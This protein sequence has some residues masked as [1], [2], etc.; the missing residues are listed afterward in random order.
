MTNSTAHSYSAI[1]PK[2]QPTSGFFADGLLGEAKTAHPGWESAL[3]S[4]SS[5][6]A[7]SLAVLATG[8]GYVTTPVPTCPEPL[9][10]V[11]S[12]QSR[13]GATLA[14]YETGS[15]DVSKANRLFTTDRYILSFLSWLPSAV[16]DIYGSDTKI[17]LRSVDDLDTGDMILEAR[18]L[19][20]LELDDDF[21]EKDATLFKKIEMSGFLDGMRHVIVSQG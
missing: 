18:V 5:N 21:D 8:V 19:S 14:Y 7:M 2:I 9:V 10:G 1:P 13:I 3:K 17:S 11:I 6:T 4:F 20:G 12:V 16:H 15:L